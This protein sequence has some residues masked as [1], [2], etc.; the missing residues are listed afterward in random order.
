METSSSCL[1][2]KLIQT[3]ERCWVRCL[4]IQQPRSAPPENSEDQQLW[5]A[6]VP[7]RESKASQAGSNTQVYEKL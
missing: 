7:D 3:V 1:G 6:L 5:N 4:S 2:P